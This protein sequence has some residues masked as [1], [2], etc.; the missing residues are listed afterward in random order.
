MS[1][2]LYEQVKARV[3][4]SSLA[5]GNFGA[6]PLGWHKDLLEAERLRSMAVA[7]VFA[8]L[9]SKSFASFAILGGALDRARSAN[10]LSKLDETS[11]A[12]I[13]LKRSDLPAFVAG[14]VIEP[15][16]GTDT[17]VTRQSVKRA[18]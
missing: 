12:D 8:N 5:Q 7:R 15:K 17:S 3:E 14:Y 10:A 16:T 1:N 13:G 18:A 4:A 2:P 6:N 9:F 11:L